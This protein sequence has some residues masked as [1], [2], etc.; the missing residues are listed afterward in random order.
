MPF[1][2]VKDFT[3][4]FDQK[5]L[6]QN[7]SLS[8]EKG[9][10]VG[11]FAPTGSGKTTILNHIAEMYAPLVKVS[12]VFQDNKLIPHLSLKKNILLPVEIKNDSKDAVQKMMEKLDLKNCADT[13]AKNASGGEK[14]R[15]NF[16]RALAYD[17]ELFLM[18]EPF[19]AQDE[20]HKKLLLELTRELKKSHTII[21]VSH[22]KCDLFDLT[23]R[24]V[25]I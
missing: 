6:L 16:A 14:Q 18:D 23:D 24:V 9:E 5:I 11:I 8:I 25:E 19:S 21:I 22:D 20:E 13:L 1:V 2:E 15:A 3:V 10:C 7:F 4:A 12:Y 17:G